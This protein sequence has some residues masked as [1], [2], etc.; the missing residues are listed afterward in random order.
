MSCLGSQTSLSK[1]SYNESQNGF[2]CSESLVRV[3]EGDGWVPELPWAPNTSLTQKTLVVSMLSAL[4]STRPG[5]QGQAD[6]ATNLQGESE[7]NQV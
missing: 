1:L 4:P 2:R 7:L 5:H 6:L 3:L